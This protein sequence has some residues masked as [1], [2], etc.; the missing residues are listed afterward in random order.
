MD[1]EIS[2]QA[3]RAV[4]KVLSETAAARLDTDERWNYEMP[5]A[6]VLRGDRVKRVSKQPRK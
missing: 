3:A 5:H 6:Y 4:W 2:K 1:S